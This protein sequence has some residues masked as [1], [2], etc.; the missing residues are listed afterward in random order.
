M[1]IFSEN[2]PLY[3]AKDIPAMPLRPMNKAPFELCWTKWC[4]E[5]PSAEYMNRWLESNENYNIGLPL[6][7]Q[8]RCVALDIDYADDSMITLIDKICP[9]SPWTRKG[10]KGKVMMFRYSGEKPFKIKTKD[11]VTI[12][13]LLSTGNQVVLPPSIH[14]E[15]K[16]PYV[17]DTNLWE[18]IDFLPVL[19]KDFEQILRIACEEHLG[20]PLSHSSWTKT[21]DYVPSGSRDTKMTSMAGIY[22]QSILRG[23]I[24]LKE[25]IGM[26][27]EWCN[28]FTEQ[29]VGDPINV[30]SGIKNIVTFLFRDVERRNRVLPKGWDNGLTDEEKTSLGVNEVSKDSVALS[31]EEIRQMILAGFTKFPEGT[32]DRNSVIEN[33]LTCLVRSQL[34]SLGEERILRYMAQTDKTVTVT[35]LKRSLAEKRSTGISGENHS[36]I[37][38]AVLTDLDNLVNKKFVNDETYPN[39]K[40]A[41]D[42]FWRW[43]GACWEQLDEHEVLS[44]ISTEYGSLPAAKRASDH[45]GIVRVARNLVSQTFDDYDQPCINFANGVLTIDGQLCPH[46]KKFGCRYILP[47]CYNPSKA[48]LDDA[49]LFKQFLFDCWGKDADYKQKVQCLREFIGASLFG[50]APMFSR[51]CLLYGTGGTGKSQMSRIVASLFPKE[52]V[53]Y[54]S[55][56]SWSDKFRITMLS[57]AI[58]NIAGELSETS[59]I[60]GEEFKQVMDGSMLQAQ[61]K[62]RDIFYF[63]CKAGHLFCS[64]YLPKTK[65]NSI[66][67]YRRWVILKFDNVV[68]EEKK[69]LNLGD[70]IGAKE[71]EA[72]CAW[73]VSSVP[74]LLN[75]KS[76]TVPQSSIECVNT[77][78]CS[79]DSVFDFFLAGDCVY[80]SPDSSSTVLISALYEKY[81]EY[82]LGDASAKPVGLRKFYQK[83]LET[84]NLLGFSVSGSCLSGIT[85][86]SKTG[87]AFRQKSI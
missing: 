73:A 57:S 86:D 39:L 15:T 80:Q 72:I 69:V 54:S 71:R 31:E 70:L 78:F 56:Y 36:E 40:F 67:F 68:N 41:F 6:G 17:S 24:T 75:K 34:D 63:S 11:N 33:V 60:S 55:P 74:E 16:K 7:E 13:E 81:R 8:S 48:S 46:D 61:F 62:G 42:K 14:P 51:C 26:L 35:G 84:A 18:V 25:A 58:L 45:V 50:I 87:T 59:F 1:T 85:L 37:A 83:L 38:R 44:Q 20:E 49:P 53:A 52:S 12:C 21:V 9:K 30:Q 3:W 43:G 5:M 27:H 77:C 22:A 82:C 79:N 19:P 47:Y 10:K 64:N 29:V 32:S 23:E 66:G 76:Y 65:D 4:S 28:N 2:A